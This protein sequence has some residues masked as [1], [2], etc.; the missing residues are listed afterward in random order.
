MNRKLRTPLL[1]VLTFLA[2][3]AISYLVIPFRGTWIYEYGNLIGLLMFYGGVLWSLIYTVLQLTKKKLNVKQNLVYIL[4]G[5]LPFLYI[6][7]MT[8]DVFIF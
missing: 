6:L 1:I 7:M 3:I 4:I 8:F 5:A 2:A